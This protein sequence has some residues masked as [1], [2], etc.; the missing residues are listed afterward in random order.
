MHKVKIIRQ[1]Y[2]GFSPDKSENFASTFREIDLPFAPFVGLQIT[3]PYHEE[4]KK[5]IWDI[6]KSVFLCFLSDYYAEHENI[7]DSWN[8]QEKIDDD[9]ENGMELLFKRRLSG[10]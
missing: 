2:D 8:F 1:I 4:I 10:T 5:I 6:N 7:G 3:T 9:L